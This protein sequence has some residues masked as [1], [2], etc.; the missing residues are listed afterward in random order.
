[1]SGQLH[2]SA[3]LSPG[4]DPGTCWVSGTLVRCGGQ[5]LTTLSKIISRFLGHAATSPPTSAQWTC[6]ACTIAKNAFA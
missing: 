6:E 2:D 5:G 4:I 3:G 1:V